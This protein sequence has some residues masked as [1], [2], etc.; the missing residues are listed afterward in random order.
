ME[1]TLGKAGAGGPVREEADTM[2]TLEVPADRLWGA[3]T[4]RALVVFGD[5]GPRSQE[6]HSIS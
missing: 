2:G 4:Q 5:A 6:P 3:Q 1:S